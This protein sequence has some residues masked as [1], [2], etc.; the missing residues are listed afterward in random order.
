MVDGLYEAARDGS[1]QIRCL[2][3][4]SEMRTFTEKNGSYNAEEGCHDERADCGGMASQ[5]M[6]LLPRKF[7]EDKRGHKQESTGFSNWKNAQEQRGS[8]YQEVYA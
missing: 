3:T 4:V 2:E 7:R 1:L 6:K 8:D 5:M